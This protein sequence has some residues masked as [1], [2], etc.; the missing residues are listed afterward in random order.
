MSIWRKIAGF[1]LIEILVVVSIAAVL[2]A[3]AY[4]S[5]TQYLLKSHRADA[6]AALSLDQTIL[7]RCYSLEFSY[8]GDCPELSEF[9]HHSAQGYYEITLSMLTSATFQL[10]A[11]ATA[12]QA[13]DKVCSTFTIDQA[14]HKLAM[15][16]SGV[17]EPDCWAM[18]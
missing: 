12:S 3:V 11:T 7:E 15:N 9:P 10:T 14:N 13:A 6:M 4:P 8:K 17:P 16:S 2:V 1:T 5:Y 18:S